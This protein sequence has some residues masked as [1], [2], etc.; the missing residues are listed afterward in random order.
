MMNNK[1]THHLSVAFVVSLEEF[2]I[3]DHKNPSPKF[4]FQTEQGG[5]VL[6]GLGA[7][8]VYILLDIYSKKRTNLDEGHQIR[9][10]AHVCP[11]S[12]SKTRTFSC[13]T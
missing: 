13:R 5:G 7:G 12:V 10:L 9:P 11:L 6:R 3:I 2:P 4:V 1:Y 8:A